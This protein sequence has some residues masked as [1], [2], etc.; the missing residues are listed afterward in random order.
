MEVLTQTPDT[1][2]IQKFIEQQSKIQ[3]N[4]SSWERQW[5]T[6]I[7]FL[8]GKQHYVIE[9]R[10]VSGIENRIEWEFKNLERKR[11]TMMTA[12][13]ILPLYRSLLSRMLLMKSR[14]QTEPETTSQR[15]V[16]AAKV[17]QELL[18]EFW[19]NV[20][21]SNSFL[22]QETAG[23]QHVLMR[24]FSYMLCICQGYLK[25]YF[26]PE[27]VGKAVFNGEVIEAKIGAVEVEVL[28]P[29]EVIRDPLRQW[30]CQSNVRSTEEIYRTYGVEVENEDVG[31][32]EFE[33]QIVSLLEGTAEEKYE[34]SSKVYQR[35]ELPSKN[36]PQGMFAVF[37]EK[38]F[39]VEPQPLPEEH[40]GKLPFHSFDFLRV[41]LS[42]FPQSMIEQLVPLQEDYN[43]TIKRIR[44]YKKWMT[45]K[46]MLPDGSKLQA[47]WDDE[48]G[49][50]IKYSSGRGTPSYL[51]APSVP[52]Q[53]FEDLQRIRKDMED[54]A[55]T[56]DISMSRVPAGV[57]SGVAMEHLS[58]SDN[59]QL[60]P[61]LGFIETQLSFFAQSVLKIMQKKYNEKRL[62]N[63]V[64][65]QLSSEIRSFTG[66]E[67]TG[68]YRIKVNLGSAM[69]Y[70]KEARQQFIFTLADKG[71]IPREKAMELLEFGDIEGVYS[72]IDK[73]SEK[74]EIQE[75]MQGVQHQPMPFENHAVR[76]KIRAD[77]MMGQEFK[78]LPDE[79]KQIMMQHYQMHAEMLRQEAQVMQPGGEP[80]KGG[81]PKGNPDAVQE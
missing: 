40:E 48:V 52:Q 21:V 41:P 61:Q 72:D 76:M 43:F 49:Q 47:K 45:G 46:V 60:A 11:K 31:P 4:R 10:P 79:L 53:L 38:Q 62:L 18:E 6:N 8:Y 59:S 27:A 26:N 51:P 75:E 36:N 67:S 44:D 74:T 58:E 12:N 65:D 77:Y 20:N 66:G 33:K 9:K 81:Q 15:D 64:G 5:L 42:P 54:I 80:P 57:K 19:E 70:S 35:Y 32:S 22:S 16:Q 25:P 50:M 78:Q 29:F 39:I 56:H 23:M 24:L 55:A 14:I 1:Q 7:A 30:V 71:Y 28:H 17:G 73:Q 69:P 34:N 3:K 37:T 68:N 13:Y 63:I 2:R